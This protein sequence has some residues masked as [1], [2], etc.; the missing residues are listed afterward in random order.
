MHVNANYIYELKLKL[1]VLLYYGKKEVVHDR[2]PPKV[3]EPISRTT[4]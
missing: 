4:V 2:N 1:T 3:A